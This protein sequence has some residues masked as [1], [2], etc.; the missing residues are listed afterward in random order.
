VTAVPHVRRT[1]ERLSAFSDGVF[2]VLITVLV[3]DLRPPELPAFKALL[4]LWPA[5]LSYAVSYLFIAIV[6]SNHHHLMRC[7]T[8]ATPR[9]LWFNF[10]HLFS[11]SLLPLSTAWMAVSELAPQPVAFYAAVFF[12]V[13][14]TYIALIWELIERGSVKNLPP[15]ERRIMRFRSIATLCIFAAA[16]IVALKYPRVGLGMCCCCLIVYL[17]PEAPGAEK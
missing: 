16:A 14:A 3:L 13:N 9:L 7:A 15:K 11:V 17:K 12:L 2:A 10:A 6:W 1:P 4:S 8:E 5:W